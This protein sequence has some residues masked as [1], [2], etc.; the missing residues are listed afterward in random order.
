LWSGH[1]EA[2]Q[3]AEHQSV[4]KI[5]DHSVSARFWKIPRQI[6]RIIKVRPFR[7]KFL[8]LASEKKGAP[9]M[10]ST[11]Y[12]GMDVHTQT[13]SIA[14][15]NSAGKVIMES[16]I[17][18]K[19]ITILQF[20]QGLH[21]DVYVTFEEGTWAAWL[22]DL[23]KPHVTKG[24][25]CNPRKNALLK[26]GNKSDRIDARKLAELLR[27]GSL[28]GVYHGEH[29]VRTLKELSRSYLTI[30]KDLGPVMTCV[31]QIEIG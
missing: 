5:P 17:E 4:E 22:Y 25:V 19:A 31:T 15:M 2:I 30:S 28:S 7:G 14:V 16:I 29:G 8:A 1:P 27:N 6:L 23:L 12:I 21:G 24:V 10:E 26:A 20:I 9:V 18:T 11:K 3:I 13:I